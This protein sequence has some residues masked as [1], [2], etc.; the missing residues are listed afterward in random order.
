MLERAAE[1]ERVRALLDAAEAGT[2]GLLIIEGEAGVGKTALLA[3]AAG[4]AR[5]RELSVLSARGGE[6]ERDLPYGIAL[7]LLDARL[8]GASPARLERLLDGAAGLAAPALGLTR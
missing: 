8:R 3:A 1:L 4:S 5:R 2:G 6:L 7:Q